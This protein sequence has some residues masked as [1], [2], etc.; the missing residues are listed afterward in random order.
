MYGK[1]DAFHNKFYT[2]SNFNTVKNKFFNLHLNESTVWN[3]GC[4]LFSWDNQSVDGLGDWYA[5]I[6]DW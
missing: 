3:T 6:Q 1:L 5:K 2:L 4:L